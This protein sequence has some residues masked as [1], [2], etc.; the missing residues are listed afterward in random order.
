MAPSVAERAAEQGVDKD[1]LVR[2]LR[3]LARWHSTTGK[4][5]RRSGYSWRNKGPALTV[6]EAALFLGVD[7]KDAERELK[8]SDLPKWNVNKVTNALFAFHKEHGRWPMRYEMRNSNGLPSPR[9]YDSVANP[10]TIRRQWV[11]PW[12]FFQR[13]IAKDRRCTPMMAVQLTNV[14]A[15]KEAIE[16]IGFQKFI[17]KGLAE[18]VDEHSEFGI[19][20][21]LPGETPTEPMML[22][23][24]VNSTPEPDGT[25]ADY[26]L[27]V[28][29]EMTNVQD[30][31]KWTFNGQEALGSL[32]YA[33]L[34]QT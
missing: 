28:P 34:V 6:K 27:R 10:W 3:V 30:A 20:Y 2:A 33:P 17:D 11:R 26:Y 16:R 1:R 18:V 31:V 23:K 14:L 21:K 12:D 19:L 9:G 24:V 15:R 13:Q 8:L 22:L 4:T 29:P 7:A 32:P 25:F 5:I